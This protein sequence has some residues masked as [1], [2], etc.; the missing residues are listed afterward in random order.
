V[1][2]PGEGHEDIRNGEQ[3]NCSHCADFPRRGY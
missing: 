1:T 3:E 2:V